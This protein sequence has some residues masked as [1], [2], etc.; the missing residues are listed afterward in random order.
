MKRT[1]SSGGYVMLAVLLVMVLAATFALVAVGAVHS[2]FSVEGAD[3]AGWRAAGGE[4]RALAAVIRSLRW[5]PSAT[6]GAAE[7]GD[8]EST[9][10]W[11]AAWTPDPV[12]AGVA[13]PRVAVATSA[14]ARRANHHERLV[15]ELRREVW[16]TGVTCAADADVEAPFSV[17]GSGIYVGGCLRGREHVI[18]LASGGAVT[19]A[20]APADVVRGE[21]FAEAAV[22]GGAG[23]FAGGVE[24]HDATGASEFAHDTDRHAGR[25]APES[26]LAGPS[27][28]FMLAAAQE[29]MGLGQA[30]EEGVLML[31]RI[32]P[33]AGAELTAGR[34]LLVPRAD[35]VTI[36]GSPRAD[37]GPLLVVVAGDAVIG[38][39]GDTLTLSGA[40]VVTGHLDVRGP[41]LI[42]GAVHAGHLSVDAP[43]SVVVPP[44]WR[45]SPL[46]G[47]VQPTLVEL[48]G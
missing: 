34:C 23:V 42:Q 17:A 47:A 32:A 27:A 41:V 21:V 16:A 6:T 28:E 12:Q 15:V 4:S 45:E 14:S 1:R 37:A 10:A 9:E 25:A 35:E 48:G 22:H 18:F 31:D 3:A 38:R 19:P 44:S 11:Q 8:A 7:G 43:M 46:S 20:G 40:L 2:L 13:W 24:I 29:A 36:V 5:R 30:L 26:W 39:P 33:A